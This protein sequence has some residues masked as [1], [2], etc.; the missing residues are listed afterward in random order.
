VKEHRKYGIP[1][2]SI[3]GRKRLNINVSDQDKICSDIPRVGRGPWLKQLEEKNIWIHDMGDGC[4]KVEVLIGA[5]GIPGLTLGQEVRLDNGL[6]AVNTVLGWTIIRQSGPRNRSMAVPV[7]S[8]FVAEASVQQLW[9]LET[10]GI[11]DP[12]EQKKKLEKEGAVR[13]HFLSTVSRKEDGRYSVSLPWI[14]G[15]PNIPTHRK[16]AEDRLVSATKK[17]LSQGMFQ[18]Y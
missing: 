16:P 5:D 7:T 13:S 9:D 11:R 15:K 18:K 3:R 1:L 12:S 10:I 2:E 4:P 8:L 6:L 17:L 14:D